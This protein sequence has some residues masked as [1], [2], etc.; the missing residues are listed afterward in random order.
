M[1]TE[2]SGHERNFSSGVFNPF[3]IVIVPGKEMVL[4]TQQNGGGCCL[5]QPSPAEVSG[6]TG[7]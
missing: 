6:A 5:P 7:L 4:L 1:H 3:L 2:G